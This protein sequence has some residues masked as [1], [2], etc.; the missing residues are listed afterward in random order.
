MLVYPLQLLVTENC[1]SARR[2]LKSACITSTGIFPLFCFWT[3]PSRCPMHS[4]E[5]LRSIKHPFLNQLSLRLLL[6]HLTLLNPNL[7]SL[8]LSNH[9]AILKIFVFFC[10]G[11]LRRVGGWLMCSFE[12]VVGVGMEEIGALVVV[13]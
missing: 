11:Q 12:A 8:K 4:F 1:R 10:M 13:L 5:F 6:P 2:G 7:Q 3:V 9:F